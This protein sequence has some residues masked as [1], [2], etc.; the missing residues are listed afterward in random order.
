[1]MMA[2]FHSYFFSDAL[3]R[4]VPFT[5]LIPQPPSAEQSALPV[6]YLLHGLSDDHTAWQRW[7]AIERYADQRGLAV[8]LPDIGR[9]FGVDMAIGGRYGTYLGRELPAAVRW[10]FPVSPAPED[11]FVAG[12]SMGGYAAFRL[13]LAMPRDYAAAASLSGALDIVGAIEEDRSWRGE[14]RAIF[15]DLRRLP[16]GRF[17]LFHLAEKLARAHMPHP[18]FYQWC[19]TDDFLLEENRRFAGHADGLGLDLTYEESPGGHNW[20]SWDQQIQRVIEWLPL[21]HQE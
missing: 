14:M 20:T 5:A 1:M 3:E 4:T 15:G 17:D 19:G 8:V 11:T 16:G 10:F 9:S 2:L 18:R 7:T 12:L 21:R 6:L 13:A